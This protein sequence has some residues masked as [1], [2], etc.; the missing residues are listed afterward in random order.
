MLSLQC[1]ACG[2]AMAAPDPSP[3]KRD[4]NTRLLAELA[5]VVERYRAHN[6]ALA[7]K[8][9]SGVT[10]IRLNGGRR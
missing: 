7:A 6:D 5:A 10:V 2:M 4:N 3:E 8:Y 9:V 1:P